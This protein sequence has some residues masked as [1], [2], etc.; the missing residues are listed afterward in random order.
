MSKIPHVS[1]RQ[2]PVVE[3]VLGVQFER[4]RGLTNS[5][6]GLF[7]ASLGPDWP[8]VEDAPPIEEQHET[9]GD[10]A[11]PSGFVR[12]A[13]R[14][15]SRTRIKNMTETAM[16]QIQPNRFHYNWLGQPGHPYPGYEEAKPAFDEYWSRF[17]DFLAQHD[18]KAGKLNQWEITYVNHIPK[19]EVWTDAHDWKN[20]FAG[21]PGPVAL[22]DDIVLG[23]PGGRWYFEIEPQKGRLHIELDRANLQQKDGPEGYVFKLTTR[24]P[25]PEGENVDVQLSAG[26]QLGH[27]VIVSAFC[28]LTAPEAQEIWGQ[29]NDNN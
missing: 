14:P 10:I 16:I 19:G 12:L 21:L 9:F 4:I 5:H 3:T 26:L 18:L 28:Q 22:S 6:L 1:F 8:H 2:P 20:I 7:W 25:L 27:D 13:T 23:D 15:S 17:Q 11:F 29:E 24:G